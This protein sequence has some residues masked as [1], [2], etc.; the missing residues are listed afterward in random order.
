MAACWPLQM[1]P[2]QKAVLISLADNAN[3]HGDCW[4]SIAT[5]AERTCFGKTAVIDA[6]KWLEQHGAL[7]ADRTN[8]RHTKY[9]VTP[10]AFNLS[11]TQTGPAAEP[12]RHADGFQLEPVREADQSAKRTGSPDGQNRSAS[13][14]GPV[15]QA[16]TN[17]QEPSETVKRKRT[18]S[19]E[20]T[21]D[22]WTESLGD[23][24]A[25]PETDAV[26]HWAQDAGIPEDWIELAWMAFDT[27]HTGKPKKQANWRQT[28]RNYV[29]LGYL[30]LWRFNERTKGWVLTDAGEAQRAVRAARE[31]RAA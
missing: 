31:R 13:R 17:R 18:R 10:K 3:D 23:A 25:I 30:K 22:E 16:D 11:A 19:A 7:E 28:F 9:R 8:G 2:T 5:I 4:P 26:F 29:E 27:L 21:F 1:P 24:D 12:V 6:I 14:T 20:L 15:R